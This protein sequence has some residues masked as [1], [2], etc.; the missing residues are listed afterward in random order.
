[1]FKGRSLVLNADANW[2]RTALQSKGYYLQTYM[3]KNLYRLETPVMSQYDTETWTSGKEVAYVWVF[4]GKW[5]LVP[6]SK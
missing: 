6:F 5:P 2:N 4:Q 3:A 1:L